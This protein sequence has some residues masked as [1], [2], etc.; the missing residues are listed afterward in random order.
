MRLVARLLWVLALL[1][2]GGCAEVTEPQG[3]PVKIT[4]EEWPG[5]PRGIPG[6]EL[7]E[8]GKEANCETTDADGKATLWL[9]ANEET[10]FT[11]EK[12]GFGSR[13][14]PVVIPTGG[15]SFSLFMLSAATVESLHE[16]AYPLEDVG[17]INCW[18]RGL[19]GVTFDLFDGEGPVSAKQYYREPG[20]PQ[21]YN[22]ELTETTNEGVGGFLEISP[23]EY[24]VQVGGT[25]G[26]CA[27]E[28]GWPPALFSERTVR[29]PVQA[30][31][32]TRIILSCSE[33]TGGGGGSAGAGGGGG[34]AGTNGAP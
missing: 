7:C 12:Q 23:G 33:G 34:E 26:D 5:F 20:P 16:D 3:E 15:E 11:A 14:V 9:P 24:E 18:V 10:G 19:A 4:V 30:G 29:F 6:V 21:T 25:A 28:M 27:L 17:G 22:D 2:F 31:Y 8:T 32:E 1:P 13:L